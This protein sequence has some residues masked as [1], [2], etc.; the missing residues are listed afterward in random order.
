MKYNFSV[1]TPAKNDIVGI[2]AYIVSNN[3]RAAIKISTRI[4]EVLDNIEKNPKIG[5]SVS[6][7]FGIDTDSLYFPVLPYTY[8]IFYRLNKQNITIDRVLDGRRDCMSVLGWNDKELP[9]D[10]Q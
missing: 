10:E 2:K 4:Y 6:E 9:D 8:I 3:K 1:T 5:G 7:R